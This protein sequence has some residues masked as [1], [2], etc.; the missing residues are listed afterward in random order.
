[1][2]VQSKP[3][4]PKEQIF[5]GVKRMF[6]DIVEFYEHLQL[7]PEEREVTHKGIK[8][9]ITAEVVASST[10]KNHLLLYDEELLQELEGVNDIYIDTSLHVTTNIIGVELLMT[11][12]IKKYNKVRA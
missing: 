7:F 4:K 8:S 9:I 2:C 11:L 6:K 12:M 3:F 5:G 10:K 1:M